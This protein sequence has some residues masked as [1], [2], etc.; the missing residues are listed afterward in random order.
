MQ[1]HHENKSYNYPLRGVYTKIDS[2]FD[3]CELM[4]VDTQFSDRHNSNGRCTIHSEEQTTC[5]ER[6]NAT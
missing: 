5:V 2:L 1:M 6:L 4:G 3:E